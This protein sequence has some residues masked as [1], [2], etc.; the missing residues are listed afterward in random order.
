[1]QKM[2]TKKSKR[3]EGAITEKI[4][5]YRNWNPNTDSYIFIY[6]QV[7]SQ[8]RGLP[9]AES[10]DVDGHK[11]IEGVDENDENEPTLLFNLLDLVADDE[12]E[13]SSEK[14]P[15]SSTDVR[16]VSWCLVPNKISYKW[17]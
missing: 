14:K 10:I 2:H 3:L 7:I 16:E 6:I 5:W 13:P 11:L 4:F 15:R 1:M 17:S 8:R 9:H 12:N